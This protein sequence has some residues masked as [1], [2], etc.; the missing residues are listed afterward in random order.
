MTGLPPELRAR[1]ALA[2]TRAVETIPGPSALRG[3]CQYEP[4]WDGFRVAIVRDE[5]TTTAWSRRGADL[6]AVFPDLVAAATDLEQAKAWFT[7]FTEAGLEGLVVK[8]L[9]VPYPAGRRE[10]LVAIMCA[11]ALAGCGTAAE[12]TNTTITSPTT[13]SAPAESSAS[14]STP[15]T[16]MTEQ[17]SESPTSTAPEDLREPPPAPIRSIECSG[18]VEGEWE[19]VRFGDLDE[20]WAYDGRVPLESCDV[21]LNEGRDTVELEELASREAGYD[22]VDAEVLWGLCAQTEG[23][24]VTESDLSEGQVAE[25]RGM[26]VLCPDFPAAEAV[27][28]NI[29]EAGEIQAQ[30][31][32]GERFH[33]GTYRVGE[34]IVPGTYV[35]EQ[36]SENCYWERLDG[37]GNIIDN[38]FTRA[39][40]RVSV[41]IAPTDYTFYSE[42]C[43][44]WVKAD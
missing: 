43:G 31:E 22:D 23:Y 28:A 39:S 5:T 42:R 7:D 15:P 44:E 30:R 24:Y 16:G 37:A 13:P 25:A 33:N 12:P 3:G 17:T 10:W 26:L 41:T 21:V 9:G 20:A 27:R 29:G 32:R 11:V 4:K 1:P 36:A 18:Q 34:D 14:Q 40:T 35:I 19:K 8:G 6:S 38:S 2:L